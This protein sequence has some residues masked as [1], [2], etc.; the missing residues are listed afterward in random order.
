M[1]I[2]ER[3]TAKRV[4]GVTQRPLDDQSIISHS[5]CKERMITQ[6]SP[7]F[8]IAATSI[9]EGGFDQDFEF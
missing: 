4:R 1:A 9:L 7:P 8:E 5:M 6:F 3:L 2:G